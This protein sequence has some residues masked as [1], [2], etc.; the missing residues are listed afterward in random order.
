MVLHAHGLYAA[1]H[2]KILKNQVVL[3]MQVQAHGRFVGSDLFEAIDCMFADKICFPKILRLSPE[4]LDAC[5]HAYSRLIYPFPAGC[6]IMQMECYLCCC[7]SRLRGRG[8]V[9]VLSDI[10]SSY[11]SACI[12]L[13]K[14]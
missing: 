7:Q 10:A 11:C 6:G 5:L 3:I 8:G 12:S 4:M 2:L 13:T 1:H 14:I 9:F